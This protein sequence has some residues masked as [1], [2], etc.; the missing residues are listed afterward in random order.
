MHLVKRMH[1]TLRNQRKVTSRRTEQ[2]SGSWP[3]TRPHRQVCQHSQRGDVARWAD[4][5]AEIHPGAGHLG[6]SA[7]KVTGAAGSQAKAV[8]A[9]HMSQRSHNKGWG[10]QKD[11]CMQRSGC[12]HE[13]DLDQ[14][15]LDWSI[16]LTTF[17]FCVNKLFSPSYY[18]LTSYL[19]LIQSKRFPAEN[20]SLLLVHIHTDRF[21]GRYLSFKLPFETNL[22]LPDLVLTQGDC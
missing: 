20:L 9:S 21:L 1:L 11:Q 8:K 16:F 7:A 17:V 5:A 4:T 22:S 6:P 19:S 3:H 13:T 12:A 10:V 18:L 15:S 2:H 14:E